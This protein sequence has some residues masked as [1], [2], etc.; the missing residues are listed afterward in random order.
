MK[1]LELNFQQYDQTT[2]KVNSKQDRRCGKTEGHLYERFVTRC[3]NSQEHLKAWI[4]D[5]DS[6]AKTDFIIKNNITDQLF[7]ISL[8]SYNRPVTQVLMTGKK[9]RFT[10]FE[11]HSDVLKYI[12]EKDCDFDS[13]SRDNVESIVRYNLVH[14][15]CECFQGAQDCDLQ[16]THL[17]LL[18]KDNNLSNYQIDMFKDGNISQQEE[19]DIC[20]EYI[21]NT[22][23]DMKIFNVEDIIL[24]ISLDESLYVTTKRRSGDDLKN[25]L[26]ICTKINGKECKLLTIKT[27]GT[28]TPNPQVMCNWPCLIKLMGEKSNEL[29]NIIQ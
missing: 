25:S 22:I 11:D 9:S 15:L 13:Q 19:T 23:K 7:C 28:S 20:N 18:K 21:N 14:L 26:G 10:F 5:A 29:S 16:A 4:Q 24:K 1:Q 2:S 8:K 12:Q 17:C 3:F 6:Q 27:H